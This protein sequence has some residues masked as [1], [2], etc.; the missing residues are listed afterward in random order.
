VNIDIIWDNPEQTILR[1]VFKPRWTWADL[2]NAMKE[3]SVQMETVSHKVNIIMDLSQASLI[4]GGAI[5]Q[6]QKA[7][8]TPK[9]ANAGI[10]VVVSSSS[11]AQTLAAIGRK[12]S[13]RAVQ[14][15]EMEFATSIDLAHEVIRRRQ[16]HSEN[17]V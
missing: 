7:F 3:A 11:F 9:H 16:P 6:A 8:A 12:L 5:A 2:H 10:T 15:W 4:P 14:N 13:G 1:Y 17:K